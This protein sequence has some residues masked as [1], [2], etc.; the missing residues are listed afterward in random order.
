MKLEFISARYRFENRPRI[1]CAHDVLDFVEKLEGD[2]DYSMLLPSI[3]KLVRLAIVH[4]AAAAT[5]KHSFR[6]SELNKTNA[7]SAND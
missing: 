3:C 1:N 6:L 5:Y 2:C 4:P 7:H